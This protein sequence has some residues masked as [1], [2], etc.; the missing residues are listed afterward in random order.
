MSD[1][2]IP[3]GRVASTIYPIT[4]F[5]PPAGSTAA[6]VKPYPFEQAFDPAANIVYVAVYNP[7]GTYNWQS[8]TLTL[9]NQ[10]QQLLQSGIIAN[11]N[12]FVQ[13]RKIY[14]LFFDPTRKTIRLDPTLFFDP[15]VARYYK[16]RQSQIGTDGSFTYVTGVISPTTGDIVSDLIDFNVVN[17]NG[18]NNAVAA[19]GSTV[20]PLTDRA[21]YV[22]EI[23]D[24]TLMLTDTL[25]FQAIASVGASVDLTPDNAVVDLIFVS[26]RI[27]T[28]DQVYMYQGEAMSDLDYRVYLKYQD[29]S[30]RDVSYQE[31]SG[32]ALQVTGLQSISTANLTGTQTPQFFT[33]TYF[34]NNTNAPNMP[35]SSNGLIANPQQLSISRNIQ[36]IV[37][38]DVLDNVVALYPVPYVVGVPGSASSQAILK[39]FALFQS[40]ALE[41]VSTQVAVT[42]FQGFNSNTGSSAT[43]IVL[44]QGTIDVYTNSYGI[45][46]SPSAVAGVASFTVG[47]TPALAITEYKAT[48][49]LGPSI[50]IQPP[51]TA[52]PA[53]TDQTLQQLF[54]QI[55]NGVTYTPNAFRI[56]DARN[57]SYIY[58]DVTPWSGNSGLFNTPLVYTLSDP[59]ETISIN[60]PLLIEFIYS[61]TNGNTTTYKSLGV[62]PA[63]VVATNQ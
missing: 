14:R 26:S 22:V 50:Q 1:P 44:G 53:V 57:F 54:T 43:Q 62:I 46:Y 10:M 51:A 42:G 13:N 52:N 21:S 34:L 17:V 63:Y 5:N 40:L 16:V 38:A 29:G 31:Y 28:E 37:Q 24:N 9:M 45:V 7:D 36:V 47:K 33:V 15:N 12:A 61:S 58:L 19:V 2:V 60:E 23:Y 6:P 11:A 56:R 39:V 3:N 18:Q 30:L 8:Q 27:I 55:I 32:G 35:N 4:F 49:S 59:T 25:V 48:A 41:D 20:I